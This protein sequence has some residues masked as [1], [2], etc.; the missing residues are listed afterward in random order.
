MAVRNVLVTGAAGFLG[1]AIVRQAADADLSVIATDR[2]MGNKS[3]DVNFVIADI[4]DPVS[5][6]KVLDGVDCVC[7]VAGLAHIFDKS[8]I[9]KAPFHDVNVVGTKNVAEAA[10]KAGVQH[11][12]FISSV[13]VYGGDSH[14]KSEDSECHP[15]SPYA[16][17]KWKAEQLLIDLCKKAGMNLTILRLATLYGEED[18]GNVARL[19]RP[20]NQGRFVWVGKG[21]NLKSLLYREDA[22]RACVE[23]IKKPQTGINIY[24]VSGPAYTMKDIVETIAAAL[25]KRMSS[26]IIPAFFALN[27]AKIVKKLFFNH[28][29]FG[30]VYD[31]LQKWL[32]NDYYNTDKYC[33]TFNYKT[34]VDLEEGIRREVEWF[35][36]RK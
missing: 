30:N 12:L 19:V 20:I 35:Q 22:A 10:A 29:K 13:S 2:T 17:S 4:L 7:H 15:E 1:S 34:T 21:T 26:F 9:S 23:V 27:S 31:T 5:L 11:F 3:P 25:G 18:P 32:A 6:S 24:N 28:S 16:E 33:N 36:K 14:G 8:E